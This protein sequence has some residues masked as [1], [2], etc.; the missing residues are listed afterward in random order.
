MTIK[1]VRNLALVLLALV[2]FSFVVPKGWHT[3]GSAEDKYDIGVWKIGGHDSSK[4]CGVIRSNKNDYFETDY[5]SLMQ[6]FSS[7]QYLG[8]RIRM[9]G[10]MKSRGVKA[11]A[12]FYV[13]ADKENSK[14]PLTFAHMQDRPIKGTT[15]WSQYKL[16]I[17]VPYNASKV[18]FGAVLHGQGQIW[19]DDLSFE[20]IGNSTIAADFVL[21]DTSLSRTPVNLNFEQ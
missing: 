19:F 8:K 20:I 14:E 7:Q 21:C 1:I 17:D 3:S 16:E 2:F 10:Y 9:T 4:N 15:D 18:A 13:R 6:T 5:G 12:G 11:W